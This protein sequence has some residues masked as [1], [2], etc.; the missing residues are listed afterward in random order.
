MYLC[1]N[2]ACKTRRTERSKSGFPGIVHT[3]KFLS[4]LT[5]S[6]PSSHF[7]YLLPSS[8]YILRFLNIL[9]LWFIKCCSSS[10]FTL[11][12]LQCKILKDE[13]GCCILVVN[14]CV[15][16]SKNAAGILLFGVC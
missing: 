10:K 7:V 15:S 16:I 2:W 11:P 6:D 1:T 12:W 8:C 13:E 3:L 4:M 5:G 14:F 9:P